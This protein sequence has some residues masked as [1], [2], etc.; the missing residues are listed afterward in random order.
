MATADFLVSYTGA[1]QAWAEWIVPSSG[2]RRLQHAAAGLGRL[3]W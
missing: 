1:D 3:S 2:G